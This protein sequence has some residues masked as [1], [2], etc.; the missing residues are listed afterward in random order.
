[1]VDLVINHTAFDSP[2]V[3]EHP[4]GTGAVPTA[5]CYIRERRTATAG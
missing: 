4:N 3:R 5:A 2:L 1:M